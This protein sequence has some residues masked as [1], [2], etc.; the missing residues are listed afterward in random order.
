M[1]AQGSQ[2]SLSE[3]N[4]GERNDQ[5]RPIATG[6]DDSGR[7]SDDSR[8]GGR[9]GL[10][11]RLASK[12][13]DL[14]AARDLE[15]ARIVSEAIARLLGTAAPGASVIDLEDERRRRAPRQRTPAAR[16][17]RC[18]EARGPGKEHGGALVALLP[19]TTI[20]GRRLASAS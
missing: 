1:V 17:P 12:L 5:R 13:A 20:S 8:G 7:A 16:G 4:E 19:V 14:A 11:G 2:W 9:A 10:L 15:G 6:A 18:S 3:E